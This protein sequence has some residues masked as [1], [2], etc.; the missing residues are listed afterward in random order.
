VPREDDPDPF[1]V[2][3]LEA[4]GLSIR[5]AGT[6]RK[7][8]PDSFEFRPSPTSPIY[9]N[10]RKSMDQTITRREWRGSVASISSMDRGTQTDDDESRSPNLKGS[11]TKNGI[12]K[13]SPV[14]KNTERTQSPASET[15]KFAQKDGAERLE[16]HKTDRADDDQEDDDYSDIDSDVEIST[17]VP[18]TARPKPGVVNVP[19]RIPPALP[20]RNPDRVSTRSPLAEGT[21]INGFEQVSLEDNTSDTKVE[22]HVGEGKV[23][24]E[25]E[26]H[27]IPPSPMEDRKQAD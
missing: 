9:N 27:S 11:P 4:E 18:V 25:D 16:E 22:R 12:S 23:N 14:L 2:K 5:E 13:F 3:A 19:K 24:G 1:G 17:A 8:T 21:V 20:P 7:A 26:F 10:Y 6:H 15:D